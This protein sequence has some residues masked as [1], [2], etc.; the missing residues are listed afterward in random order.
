MNVGGAIRDYLTDKGIKQSF[1]VE[2]TGINHPA[3][4]LILQD[5]R[6][7]DITEYYKICK[8]LEVPLDTFLKE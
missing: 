3:L 7:L 1:I 4:S 2:K 5:R 6:K 8:A